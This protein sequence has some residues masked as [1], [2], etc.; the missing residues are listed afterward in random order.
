MTGANHSVTRWRSVSA[1]QTPA[2]AGPI[3]PFSFSYTNLFSLVIHFSF[4]PHPAGCRMPSRCS[5]LMPDDCS[6][7]RIS[8]SFL[9][10]HIQEAGGQIR[11]TAITGEQCRGGFSPRLTLGKCLCTCTVPPG[12]PYFTQLVQIL[13]CTCASPF[14]SPRPFTEGGSHPAAHRDPFPLSSE[15]DALTDSSQ[16]R[17]VDSR[18]KDKKV[19][20]SCLPISFSSKSV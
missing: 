17:I 10:S 16:R 7:L 6:S 12:L 5:D 13:Y 18:D 15:V 20:F 11:Q 9:F 3:H 8:S 2:D 4:V 19:C 1:P 14:T